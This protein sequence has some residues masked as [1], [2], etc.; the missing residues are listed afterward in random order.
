MISRHH[1]LRWVASYPVFMR[2]S[3]TIREMT[4][5][6]IPAIVALGNEVFSAEKSPTLYRAWEEAE[7]LRVYSAYKSTCLVADRDGTIVGF[8]LGSLLDKPG[9]SW[10]YGWLE[11]LGVNPACKRQHVARRLL[12]QL[13]QRFVEEEVR[14]MLVDT[15]EGNRPALNLFRAFG[16]EKEIKHVYLSMNLDSHPRALERKFSE[17]LDVDF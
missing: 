7:V 10:K 2:S 1:F 17:E 6:D 3:I 15:Y 12:K 4:V 9:N 16:F 11:W 14:M 8:A 13:C 5:E